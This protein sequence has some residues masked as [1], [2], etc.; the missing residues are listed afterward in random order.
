MKRKIIKLGAGGIP[1][2]LSGSIPAASCVTA[3]KPKGATDLATS[4]INLNKPGTYNAAPAGVAPTWNATDGWIFDGATQTL[5]TGI[6]FAAG[7]NQTSTITARFTAA[8]ALIVG[9]NNGGGGYFSFSPTTAVTF[10]GYIN[11]TGINS[12]AGGNITAGIMAVAG[13]NCYVNGA[14]DGTLISTALDPGGQPIL[15]GGSAW[16]FSVC[17]IQA[18]A[19]YSIVLTDAQ[20][21][22]VSAAM[23]VL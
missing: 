8:T 1:W 21:A 18:M 4:Y 2:Y 12:V 22:A 17:K 23:A 5:T 15:I 10:R 7:V 20:I 14:P 13:N 3:Y 6:V 9:I 16:T 11:G 19:V